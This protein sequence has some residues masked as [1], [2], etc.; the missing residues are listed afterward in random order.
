[1]QL[2]ISY[3]PRG[4]GVADETLVR[5]RYGEWVARWFV[6]TRSAELNGSLDYSITEVSADGSAAEHPPVKTEDTHLQL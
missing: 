3:T 5:F 4:D 2:R 6:I 1:M